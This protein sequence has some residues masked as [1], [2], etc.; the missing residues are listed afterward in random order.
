MD[1]LVRIAGKAS[2][3]EM[4]V[5]DPVTIGRGEENVLR[6]FDET[7]S[8]RHAIV[9]REKGRIVVEDLGSSNGTR[10]NGKRVRLAALVDGDEIA[11]GDVALR[12]LA[13]AEST[14]STVIAKSS[15]PG[16]P[17][18][19][20]Q[21]SRPAAAPTI[22]TGAKPQAAA[23]SI[24]GRS[25]AVLRM[26]ETTDRAAASDATVLVRGETGTGKELVARRLHAKS[27]RHDGP[28]VALNCAAF[29]EG[30]VESELFGHEKG[31]FTGADAR[32]DGRIAEAAGGTF[33]LDEVGELS[34]ALQAK[35]LRVLS[36]RTFTRVGGREL[37]PMDCRLVAATHRDLPAMVREKTFREDL[38]YRLA[39]V[40][41]ECPPLRDRG[42][43]LDLLADAFLVRI[44]ARLGGPTPKLA[45]DAR[46]RL[47]AH[48]WPGNVR[49]LENAL[50]R[51]IVLSG[52]DVLTAADLPLDAG[53]PAADP[54][55][56]TTVTSI[57]EAEKRAVIAALAKTKGKKGEAAAL[58]GISWPTLNRKLKEY[59]LE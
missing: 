28:F 26:I 14:R 24:V 34:A 3:E 29:V 45:P 51:A 22:R 4:T 54:S 39:V 55:T 25:P 13:G 5:V 12:F 53:V 31:A 33:F 7:A 10:V 57:A 19:R 1:R 44:A 18:G 21:A 49:E 50:E 46:K 27:A 8:R 9:R 58:L 11:F 41:I 52:A 20:P 36:D 43:D 56:D 48:A 15:S 37:H 23:V 47:H 2:R 40:T 30:L 16:V 35:L 38:W 32:K 59:G 6:L 17:V 42:D